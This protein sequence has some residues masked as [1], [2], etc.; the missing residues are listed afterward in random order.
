MLKDKFYLQKNLNSVNS[1]LKKYN[2]LKKNIVLEM[3]NDLPNI[4][5]ITKEN[6]IKKKISNWI[7]IIFYIII[8]FKLY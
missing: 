3:S 5:Q 4:E 8:I 7:K 1:A 2:N 6:Y